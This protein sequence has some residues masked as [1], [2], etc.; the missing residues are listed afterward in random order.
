VV[1]AAGRQL[2]IP[3]RYYHL[4]ECRIT[5]MSGG[6]MNYVKPEVKTIGEAMTVIEFQQKVLPVYVEVLHRSPNPAYDLDE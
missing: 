2:S 6:A 4:N 3:I 1:A 5:E